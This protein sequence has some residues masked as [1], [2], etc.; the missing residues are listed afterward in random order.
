MGR[1]NPNYLCGYIWYPFIHSFI[2]FYT[3]PVL[4]SDLYLYAELTVTGSGVIRE[5][6]IRI[7]D[8]ETRL[9]TYGNKKVAGGTAVSEKTVWEE[10]EEQQDYARQ[11]PAPTTLFTFGCI[12]KYKTPINCV[13]V[14]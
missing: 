13:T 5:S 14:S 11:P 4:G 9:F 7:H 8:T 2:S 3:L 6:E 10:R 12:T 1:S